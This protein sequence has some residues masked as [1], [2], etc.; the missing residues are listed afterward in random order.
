[1]SPSAPAASTYDLARFLALVF[2]AEIEQHTLDSFHF[3]EHLFEA[4]NNIFD[5]HLPVE[6]HFLLFDDHEYSHACENNLMTECVGSKRSTQPVFSDLCESSYKRLC[7]TDLC[8]G[9]A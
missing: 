6:E 8:A 7:T 1:M 5:D 9:A 3:E 4:E 2:S